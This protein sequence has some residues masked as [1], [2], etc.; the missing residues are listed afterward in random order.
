MS[1]VHAFRLLPGDDLMLNLQNYVKTHNIKA[2]FV[3]LYLLFY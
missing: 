3:S 1:K 2:G